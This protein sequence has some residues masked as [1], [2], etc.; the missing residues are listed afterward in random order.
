[1]STT[2]QQWK[3][4]LHSSQL[5]LAL[6]LKKKN[7]TNIIQKGKEDNVLIEKKILISFVLFSKLVFTTIFLSL[8]IVSTNLEKAND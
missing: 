3:Q 6:A 8:E 1:M 5:A 2:E 4:H 7:Y